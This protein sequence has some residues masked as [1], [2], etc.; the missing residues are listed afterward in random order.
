[1]AMQQ[2]LFGWRASAPQSSEDMVK[3]R[4]FSRRELSAM[5]PGTIL[6]HKERGPCWIDV[7][8]GKKSLA[9]EPGYHVP[10]T[11]RGADPFNKPMI[12]VFVGNFDYVREG[13]GR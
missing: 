5:P 7:F 10:L 3:Y 2:S 1:M 6:R 13:S 9:F 8:E 11:E 12:L 4:V